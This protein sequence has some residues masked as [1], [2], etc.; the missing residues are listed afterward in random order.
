MEVSE[1]ARK[2]LPMKAIR[3]V[4]RLVWGCKLKMRQ[5]SRCLG[6]GKTTIKDYLDRAEKAGL[7]WPLPNMDDAELEQ[8]LFPVVT[9][10]GLRAKPLP[11]LAWI[12]Q[13]L[14]KKNVTLSLLWHEYKLEHPDGLQYSQFC[15]RYRKWKRKQD[16]VMR[17]T[18]KVG[19]KTIR[20]LWRRDDSLWN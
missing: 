2:R 4:L 14:M 16:L 20:G 15:D 7:K 11:D 8:R 3:E 13:E 17:Q 5:V 19:R 1:V 9:K 10:P 18:H 12:R 6:V